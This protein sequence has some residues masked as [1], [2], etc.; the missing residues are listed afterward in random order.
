MSYALCNVLIQQKYLLTGYTFFFFFFL[1]QFKICTSKKGHV[2]LTAEPVN[3]F[4]KIRSMNNVCFEDYFTFHCSIFNSPKLPIKSLVTFCSKIKRNRFI[5]SLQKMKPI[6]G[7]LH[8][9]NFHDDE[10]H[11]T[12]PNT[13]LITIMDGKISFSLESA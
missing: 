8:H 6:L 13:I 1:L 4:C 2:S 12:T 9:D 7:P 3:S 11:P 10:K 5:F